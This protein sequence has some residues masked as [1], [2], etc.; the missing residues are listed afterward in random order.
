MGSQLQF[1]ADRVS[2]FVLVAPLTNVRSYFLQFRH[3]VKF[4]F[5]AGENAVSIAVVFV[6]LWDGRRR[7][8]RWRLNVGWEDECEFIQLV[9]RFVLFIR[10][11]NY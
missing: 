5:R 8:F 7:K 4:F 2:I 9:V 1:C 11:F 3:G 10:S 6:I